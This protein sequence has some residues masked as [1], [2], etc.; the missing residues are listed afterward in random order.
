MTSLSPTISSGSSSGTRW[1]SLRISPLSAS[2][3]SARATRRSRSLSVYGF[4]T[5]S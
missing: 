5:R 4:E 2:F 3:S 1:R